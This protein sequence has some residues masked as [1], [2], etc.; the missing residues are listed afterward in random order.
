MSA[1]E[2]EARRKDLAHVA[3]TQTTLMVFSVCVRSARCACARAGPSLDLAAVPLA[4][5][6]NNG[7]ALQA[8]AG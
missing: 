1:I 5:A 7:Q 2:S 4:L 8:R 6:A 3:T